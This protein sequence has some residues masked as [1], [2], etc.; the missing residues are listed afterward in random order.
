MGGL[1]FQYSPD[2]KVSKIPSQQTNKKPTKTKKLG[3]VAHD[4]HPRYVRK[5][6]I[7]GSWSKQPWAKKQDPISKITSAKRTRVVV[8]AVECLPNKYKAPNSSTSTRGNKTNQHSFI[9]DIFENTQIY[10]VPTA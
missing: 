8:Q 4:C 1:W 7:R 2:K 10:S 3:V 9:S 5:P 6:T